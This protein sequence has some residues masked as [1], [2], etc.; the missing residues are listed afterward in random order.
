MSTWVHLQTDSDA[1]GGRTEY[2]GTK[3]STKVS[4]LTS[5]SFVRSDQW[6]SSLG[7]EFQHLSLLSAVVLYDSCC[8][9]IQFVLPLYVLIWAI[10]KRDVKTRSNMYACKNT[11]MKQPEVCP[12]IYQ[13]YGYISHTHPRGREIGSTLS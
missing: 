11:N 6:K 3:P 2:F 7:D 1:P 10:A 12:S 13:T 5:R 4:L 9:I 8:C